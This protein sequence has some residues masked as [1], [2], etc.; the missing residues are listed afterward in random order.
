MLT[1]ANARA[2]VHRPG[3]LDYIGVKRFD[4]AGKVVGERRFV[5]LYTSSA[6]HADPREVPLLRRKVARVVERA[7]FRQYSHMYKNLLSVLQDYPRDE[8]FQVDEDTLL[9]TALGILRLGDRRKTRVF[10]RRDLYG[11]FYSCLVFMPRENFNTDVRVKIQE[12]LKRAPERHQ[13]SEFTVQ[14]SEAVLARIHMLV[15]TKPARGARLRHPRD[16]GGHRARH[17]PLGGR[18]QGR[19]DRG[20]GRGARH[21][22]RCAPTAAHSPSPIATRCRRAPPCA[23]S[24]SWRSSTPEQPYARE[25]LPPGRGRRADAAPARL[26]PRRPVPLSASLPVL[27]NMGLEVLDEG[28]YEIAA[29][30]RASPSSS[31]T[32]ACAAPRPIPDVEAIKAITEEALLRV[33][34]ARDRE[35][36]LQPPHARAPRSPPTT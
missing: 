23:T 9:E 17:A 10:I 28:S 6:Y 8:L 26:P 22:A 3:Y 16:R 29:R 5:G 21:R 34:R 31:T 18:P 13:R 2:T 30:G 20:A 27:E 35:R 12:I 32:S 14:L 7:G 33:A 36:R 4:A 24:R 11:R 19:A 25:P 1:K 15:R